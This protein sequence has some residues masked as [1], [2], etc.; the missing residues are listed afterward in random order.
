MLTSAPRQ[1]V[2]SR[3]ARP[4]CRACPSGASV[5]PVGDPDISEVYYV[6]SGDGTFTVGGETVAIK[7]GNAPL[8][9]LIVGVAR[10]LQA[11]AAWSAAH[12]AGPDAG[13]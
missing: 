9:F 8:A 13:R 4:C 1:S 10:N 6:L 5:G 2:W 11:K 7:S 3:P 12:P